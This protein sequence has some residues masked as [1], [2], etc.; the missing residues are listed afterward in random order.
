MPGLN[1]GIQIQ[2]GPYKGRL[3]LAERLDCPG[4]DETPAY[5]RSYVLYSDDEVCN[6]L[7]RTDNAIDFTV[8]AC[9]E[10]Q[11]LSR[12]RRGQL[13]NFFQWAGPNAR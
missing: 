9:A 5:W 4:V 7:I 1:H 13:V 12:E 10:P 8:D 3:A 6:F 11:R 2:N